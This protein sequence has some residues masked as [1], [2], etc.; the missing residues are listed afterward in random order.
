MSCDIY[1]HLPVKKRVEA[2]IELL[3]YKCL[4]WREILDPNTLDINSES[5][6]VLGQLFGSYGDGVDALGIYGD[7]VYYG[8]FMAPGDGMSL[9]DEWTAH[10]TVEARS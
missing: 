8:F 3:D 4:G 5:D 10:L 6:C 1:D 7:E 9:R 2:G